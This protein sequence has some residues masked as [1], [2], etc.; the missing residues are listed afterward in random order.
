LRVC[1]LSKNQDYTDLMMFSEAL[2][3]QRLMMIEDKMAKDV[4][5]IIQNIDELRSK[6]DTLTKKITNEEVKLEP[7]LYESIT[8]DCI[9][10]PEEIVEAIKD[11]TVDKLIVNPYE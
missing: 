1:K 3:R 4:S 7:S 10:K 5:L 6:V 9:G 2:D 8:S 11:G